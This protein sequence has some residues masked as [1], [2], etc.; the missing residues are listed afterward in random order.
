MVGCHHQRNGHE[1]EQTPGDGRGQ[2][3]LV[4]CSLWGFKELDMTERLNSNEFYQILL[5]YLL[6]SGLFLSHHFPSL[7]EGNLPSTNANNFKGD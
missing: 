1:L 7:C 5:E 4:C 2:G 6:S 3:G